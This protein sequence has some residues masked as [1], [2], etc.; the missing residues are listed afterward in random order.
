[1]KLQVALTKSNG[2]RAVVKTARATIKAP[3]KHHKKH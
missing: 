2:K 3:K 1:V